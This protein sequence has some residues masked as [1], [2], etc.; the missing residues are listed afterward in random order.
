L[1][2]GITEGT[3]ERESAEENHVSV[4]YDAVREKESEEN[5][6]H[7]YRQAQHAHHCSSPALPGGKTSLMPLRL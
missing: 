1:S 4:S 3:A 2:S 7:V 5:V 6:T